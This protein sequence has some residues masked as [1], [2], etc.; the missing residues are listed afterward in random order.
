MDIEVKKTAALE[1][2]NFDF[3]DTIRCISMMG[4]VWEHSAIVGDP[5]IKDLYLSILHVSV[6]QFFKFA[7]IAF[8]LIAGFLINYKFTEYTPTQYLKN[9]FKNTIKPWAFWLHILLI[10]NISELFFKFLKYHGDYPIPN[11]FGLYILEQYYQIIFFSSFWFILNF[12]ICISILLIFKKHIY[13]IWFGIVLGCVSLFYSINLYQDWIITSHTTALFGF[14]FYLWLGV[15]AN[16]YYDQLL[17]FMRKTSIWWF[18]TITVIF[19]FIADLESIYLKSLKIDDIY[20]TL[21]IS[22]ILYSLS[23]FLV[24]FKI[25]SINFVNKYLD[26]RNTTFG[27]YLVHHIIIFHVL[28]EIFRPFNIDIN[29]ITLLQATIYTVLRFVITYLLS[30]LI[31]MLIR[32]TKFKWSVGI[33]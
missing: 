6:M 1:K 22:N 8:F 3:V 2:K 17:F 7:T 29:K 26:P 30:V 20:N 23:F 11:N 19:F 13:N 4:I 18:I 24:L 25:G 16:K 31:V 27:I 14:V 28:T 10:W 21:R 15:Y 12:L 9:R 33:S 5:K 32:R